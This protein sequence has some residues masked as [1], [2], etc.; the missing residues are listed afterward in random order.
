M[1]MRSQY[2]RAVSP[3]RTE[4]RSVIAMSAAADLVRS[5]LAAFERGDPD[6]IAS[7]VSDGFHNEHFS[8]IASSCTGKDE[9]RSRLPGFLSDFAGRTYTVNGLVEEAKDEITEVVARY[10][11]RAT[12]EGSPIDIPG[13]MWFVV[14]DGTI[15]SRTDVWDS[16]VFFAQTRGV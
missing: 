5:Y 4:A 8:S 11:F 14:E 1:R 2:G 10:N 13:M 16:G 6:E 9:Y 3:W 7:H 15:T 12:F